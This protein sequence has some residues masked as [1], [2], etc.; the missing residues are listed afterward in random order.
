M[1]YNDISEFKI[2]VIDKNMYNDDYDLRLKFER[3]LN[4]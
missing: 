2:L 4:I 1:G 3:A